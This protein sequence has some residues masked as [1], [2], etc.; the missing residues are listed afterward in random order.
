MLTVCGLPGALSAMVSVAARLPLA[1]EGGVKVMLITQVALDAT[2]APLVQVLPEA[3][4]KSEPLVP[5]IAGAAVM[6]NVPLP[7]FF[8]VTACAELVVVTSWPLKASGEGDT[9]ATGAAAVPVPERLMVWVVGEA[10]S[11]MVS[12]A[13]PRAPRAPGVKV[14]LMVQVSVG[15]TRLLLV[16]VVPLATAKSAELAPEMATAVE[17]KTRLPVPLFFTVI[18]C[19]ELVELTGCEPKL[20]AEVGVKVTVGKRT[21]PARLTVCEPAAVALTPLL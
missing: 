5:E 11:V 4:A 12:V 15:A 16:Q 6:F 10:L 21:V 1:P 3:M 8:T 14:T 20:M 17:P 2:V 9:V 7:V 18:D 19:G 13:G